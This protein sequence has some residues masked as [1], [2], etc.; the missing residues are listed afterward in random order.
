MN[1]LAGCILIVVGIVIV[2]GYM[3]KPADDEIPSLRKSIKGAKL[4]WG[5]WHTGDRIRS[6]NLTEIGSIKKILLLDPNANNLA[7]KNVANKAKIRLEEAIF[8]IKALTEK[9]MQE[10]IEVRWHTQ[11]IGQAITIYDPQPVEKDRELK[12]YSQKAW[13]TVQVLE[14]LVGRDQRQLY[15]IRKAKDPER[16][17]KYIEEFE[18]IWKYASRKPERR[19]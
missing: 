7:L 12:P 1:V 10:G 4:V 9:A 6:E 18:R 5:Q 13:L 16:F 2:L 19:A 14:P 8:E 15:P 11:N 3:L 17:N